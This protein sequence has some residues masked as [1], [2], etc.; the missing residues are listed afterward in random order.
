MS[1]GRPK[2]PIELIVAKGKTNMSKAD[3]EERRAQEV[4]VPFTDIEPPSYLSK[5]QKD[6]FDEIAYKLLAIG[7]MT[8]LDE[9]TLARYIVAKDHYVIVTKRL[10]KE[11]RNG[12][13]QIVDDLQK[14]QQRAF[15]QCRTG[16]SDLGLTI[17]SRARLVVPEVEPPKTNKFISKFNNIEN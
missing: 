12:S 6:E 17:T 13:I 15:N 9:E 4:K 8:E 1:R 2:Q 7:I 10:N 14:I 3:I 5:K 11:I 16:A